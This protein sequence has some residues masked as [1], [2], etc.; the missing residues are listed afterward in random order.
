MNPIYI[1]H[2]KG[3][4]LIESMI[5]IIVVGIGVLG[6]TKLNAVLLQ[7]TG[8]SKTRAAATQIAQDRAE[9]ARREAAAS[10]CG[11]FIDVTGESVAGVN[12]SYDIATNFTAADEDGD[13]TNDRVSI[14]VTV[15][16]TNSDGSSESTVLSSIISCLPVST[17]AL[18]DTNRS[19]GGFVKNPTG[20]GVIGGDNDYE[21]E[22]IPGVTNTIGD[23][24]LADGTKTNITESG[25]VEI[26][27]DATGKVLLSFKK[28]GCEQL[29]QDD[30][31][32][33]TVSGRLFIETKNGNP[34]VGKTDLFVLSSDTSYCTVLD[35]T[36]Q[37]SWALSGIIESKAVS[38]VYTYYQCY[39]GPEWWG[40]IGAV[41][42][43]SANTNDRIC[44][45][46]PGIDNAANAL[47]STM[48][49]KSSTRGYRGY[50][51]VGNG[52]YESKGI[53]MLEQSDCGYV[54][55]HYKDHHLVLTNI[56]GSESCLS[57]EESLNAIADGVLNAN[58]SESYPG[59][60]GKFFCMTNYDINPV[61]PNL[62]DPYVAASTLVHGTIKIRS[63]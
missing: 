18:V 17:Q 55:Q 47:F 49:V 8:T 12:A 59:N 42:V 54:A 57:K 37:Q 23:T 31:G 10:A 2:K 41:R 16:W 33:S 7:G 3:F 60:P 4:M 15:S 9:Q 39:I 29:S 52:L 32:F 36:N 35:Y 30:T 24:D 50:V 20:R 51:E 21:G 14:S 28:N 22:A 25:I 44:V 61:C 38:F 13:G 45:G 26:I 58:V 46:N 5:A 11:G 19:L 53:G 6:L 56:T 62:S 40:N 48:P 27:D 1:R 43:D 34:I 63:K